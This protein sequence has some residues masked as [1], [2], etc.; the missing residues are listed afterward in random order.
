MADQDISA[1]LRGFAQA[2][3]DGECQEAPARLLRAARSATRRT[4]N[5]PKS[6]RIPSE[7]PAYLPP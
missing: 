3:V 5:P 7:S 4:R 2:I 1:E 6:H